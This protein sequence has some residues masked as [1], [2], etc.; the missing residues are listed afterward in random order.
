MK[1]W[2]F[3]AV[4]LF[5]NILLYKLSNFHPGTEW[6]YAALVIV[7]FVTSI[8][9]WKK[10]SSRGMGV[11]ALTALGLFT[12]NSILYLLMASVFT[13]LFSFILGLV[14][15]PYYYIHREAVITAWWIVISNILITLGISN[16]VVL[17]FTIATASIGAVL[18]FWLR[19]SMMKM[20][21]SVC[22]IFSALFLIIIFI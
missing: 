11:I 10:V 18:G 6:V 5:G 21:F 22:F 20:F 16:E 3:Y 7:L 14:L 8:H 2:L 15:L 1:K 13:V 4:I 19:S 12:I 9:G 17:W